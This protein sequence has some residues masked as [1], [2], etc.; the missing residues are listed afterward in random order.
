MTPKPTHSHKPLTFPKGFLWG[1][2]TSSHQVEGNNIHNDWWAWEQNHKHFKK[3]GMATDH[4][5]RYEEDFDIAQAHAHNAH[6]LS[7]EWSRIEPKQGEW[8]WDAV[9][10][11]RR[12]LTAL[13]NRNIK[14]MLTLHHFTTPQWLTKRGGWSH[15]ETAILFAGYAE[16]VAQHLGNLVDSWITI[17]EPM[18]YVGQSYI[19]GEWPPQHKNS[20]LETYRVLRNMARAHKLAYD[21]IH[22]AVRKAHGEAKVGIAKNCFSFVSYSYK[23]TDYVRLR[24]SEFGWNHLFFSWTKKHHDFIGINYYF[25]QRQGRTQEG[26]FTVHDASRA[27]RD[28]SDLGWE[29]YAPGLFQVLMIFRR[30]KLPI[31]ITENGISTRNDDKRVRYILSHVKEVYHAIQAGVDVRGYFHWALLDNFEWAEGYTPRFGLVD[32]NYDTLERTPK[33]SLKLY[34]DIISHNGITHEL[35]RFLGHGVHYEKDNEPTNSAS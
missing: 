16:F 20:Y 12:V 21:R 2:S 27:D 35:L 26:K 31:Y 9:E 22:K 30:Y 4:Y 28:R 15:K 25:H 10:H 1:A 18:V 29:I 19:A 3:S 7:I 8:D 24:V 11:Y 33:P 23:F 14:V 13:Q 5:N 32:I 34:A 6:R 17:N